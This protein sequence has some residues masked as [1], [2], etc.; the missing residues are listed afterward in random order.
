[1]QGQSSN[2]APPLTARRSCINDPQCVPVGAEKS[3]AGAKG[4]E[5]QYQ[6]VSGCADASALERNGE[7]GF[8]TGTAAFGGIARQFVKGAR[9][10]GGNDRQNPNAIALEHL[11]LDCASLEHQAVLPAKR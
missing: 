11:V 10:Q 8:R 7:A 4:G 2:R 9:L 5:K 6:R 1:M 3:Q